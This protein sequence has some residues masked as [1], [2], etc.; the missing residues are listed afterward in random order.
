MS[1]SFTLNRVL[2][3]VPAEPGEN[4]QVLLQRMGIPSVRRADALFANG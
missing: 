1:I 2:R 4:L 3:T